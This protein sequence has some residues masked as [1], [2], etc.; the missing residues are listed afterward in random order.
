MKLFNRCGED[1]VRRHRSIA[2]A[3]AAVFAACLATTSP[4][5]AAQTTA[6]PTASAAIDCADHAFAASGRVVEGRTSIPWSYFIVARAGT[7]DAC[8]DGPDGADFDLVLRHFGTGGLQT[9]ATS[10]GEEDVKTLSYE[11]VPGAYRVD[12]VAT[13][14]SGVYTVG[15]TFP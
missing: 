4:A 11:G 9:V 5:V 10:S 6:V 7:I 8:L 12:V 2:T 15:V 13:S 14:G 1:L 3:G